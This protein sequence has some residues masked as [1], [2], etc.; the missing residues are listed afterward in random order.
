MS[1]SSIFLFNF[2][3]WNKNTGKN[4]IFGQNHYGLLNIIQLLALF[5]Y[6]KCKLMSVSVVQ[7]FYQILS[8]A[9]IFNRLIKV[10]I[11]INKGILNALFLLFCLHNLSLYWF[12]VLCYSFCN[13]TI[14]FDSSNKI[15]YEFPKMRHYSNLIRKTCK[16]FPKLN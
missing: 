10:F 15:K 11:L 12:K 1:L 7:I 5:L 8:N 13:I 6:H 14:T 2:Y 9:N 16:P 4:T 3:W